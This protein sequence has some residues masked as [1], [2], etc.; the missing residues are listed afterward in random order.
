[1]SGTSMATPT[2]AGN[3]ALMRQFFAEGFY[4]RGALLDDRIFADNFDGTAP[5]ALPSADVYNPSGMAMKA[6]LLNGT[7]PV[8]GG[9]W[10]NA[11][12]G[13]GRAW[14]DGNLWFANTMTGGDDSR[15]SRLFERTNKAGMETGD[16]HEYTIANVA[17][18]KELR[19][20]LTWF[21]PE[22]SV[23]AA[24]TLVND[25]DLEVVGPG[26]TYL[27]NVFTNGVSVTGGSADHKNTVEQVRLTA[28]VA[29]SYTLR[30][31]G[32]SIPGNGRAETDR[33][34]YALVVSGG[35]GIPDQ[36]PFPAPTNLAVASNGV[37]G[38]GIG[39]NAAS[40]SQSFQLY[41][42]NGSC[43]SAAAGDFR[44][45]A[46]GNASPLVDNRSQ[47]GFQY[48]YK[49]RGVSNDVEGDVSACIDVVSA[50]DCTL[51][52]AFDIASLAADGSNA[53]C[54][55]D[56]SWTAATP[57]CP[58]ATGVTYTILRDT[59]PY[60]SAPTQLGAA[61]VPPSYSD[62]AVTNGTPRT[63]SMK[64][65]ENSRTAGMRERRPSASNMPSGSE[66]TMPTEATTI[67]TSMPPHKAVSTGGNPA[68]RQPVSRMNEEIGNTTKK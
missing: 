13:W 47:G 45:V 7:N 65:T 55:V 4:P 36:T 23:G 9:N 53:T 61:I 56:L 33:Q 59:D 26:G 68:A 11:N 1:M 24:S 43:A 62:T 19:A 37:A 17:A 63:N 21:D 44:L 57:A 67:V 46:N 32:T 3:A 5:S 54:K 27:G 14:L 34:G 49:V 22:A 60:F 41:R 35:F 29:G 42:A 25:L 12:I 52:P 6:F 64:I 18:G 40:G 16:V 66:Q 58:T 2:I 38:I 28:P 31:K 39:F 50:D 30:V 10:P 15:R 48:A 8:Q 20:T 51:Q